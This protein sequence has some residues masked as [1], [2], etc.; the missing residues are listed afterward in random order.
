VDMDGE[1]IGILIG[2]MYGCDNFSIVTPAKLVRI[3]MCKALA[4]IIME[5]VE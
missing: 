4:K 3:A 1:C 5:K 2:G